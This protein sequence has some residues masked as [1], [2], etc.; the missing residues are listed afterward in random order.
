MGGKLAVLL[1]HPIQYQ[2]P[3]LQKLAEHLGDDLV[4]LYCARHGM[5]AGMDA[6]FG[7]G[8]EWD[9]PL[10]SGYQYRLL[11][12]FSLN[13]SVN[14]FWGLMNWGLI[15][16]LFKERPQALL[17]HGYTSFSVFLA[18][19]VCLVLRIP[20]LFRGETTLR[21]DTHLKKFVKNIFFRIFFA[22]I[23][24]IFYIGKKSKEFYTYYKIPE[25][26][27]F[28]TPYT[29]DND[30][31]LATAKTL[32]RATQKAA[33]GLSRGI[34]M[35]LTVGKLIERKRPFD[36]L[37]AFARLP[38]GAAS[39]VFVGDG[40][41]RTTLEKKINELGLANIT[42]TGFKNQKELPGYYAAA[43]VFAFASGYES[44]GLVV[45]E[46]MCFSLPIITTDEVASSADLVKKNGVVYAAGD[47]DALSVHLSHLI[48]NSALRHAM[49]TESRK[50]IEDWSNEVCVQGIRGALDAVA[51]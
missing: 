2:S 18:Y 29:I 50:I 48:A 33:L 9:R 43:D 44:F 28:F 37:L 35:I 30:F 31:F 1:S 3:L 17:I 27:L 23:A 32:D 16:F 20:I 24:G 42:I 40:P 19:A 8:Y 15:P 5:D 13:P 14:H 36:L 25:G 51:S 41:L 47:I 39:L 46:A 38:K 26:K 22:G 34:P 10:L 11:K 7:V 21:S 6:G 45:N 4:V 12:N 49:G